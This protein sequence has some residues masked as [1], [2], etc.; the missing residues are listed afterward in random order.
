VRRSYRLTSMTFKG[1]CNRVAV[2]ATLY[3]VL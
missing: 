2:L 1:V 3:L